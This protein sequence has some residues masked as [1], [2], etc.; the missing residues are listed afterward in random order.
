MGGI[1]PEQCIL[2][3]PESRLFL[4]DPDSFMMES[5]FPVFCL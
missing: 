4:Y 1:A 2:F 5:G 3:A